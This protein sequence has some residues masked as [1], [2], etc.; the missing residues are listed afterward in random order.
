M[1]LTEAVAPPLRLF[2][3]RC[4][5]TGGSRKLGRELCVAFAKAGAKVAFT[6]HKQDADAEVTRQLLQQAG[7]E[8]LV[9]KGSVTDADHARA[10][11]NDIVKAW[12]GLDVLVNN[13]GVMQILPVALLE[14]ADWDKVIDT[15][16]K[17]AYI[18]SREV[19]RPMLRA[20]KG[21]IL[22]IGSIAGERIVEAPIHYAAA[23]AGL[24]GLTRALA[25]EVGRFGIAVND[26]SAGLLAA[27][28]GQQALQHHRDEYIKNCPLGRLGTLEELAAFATWLVSDENSFMSGA[29]LA[30]DGG[31]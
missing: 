21:H 25:R 11:V 1:N 31:L 28:L 12:G 7:A 15:N 24:Q 18:F 19:L 8:V 9:F 6:Y 2:G 20:K 10:T 16:L 3:K 26:L 4:L 27:G 5:V 13:A 23:K 14:E 29:R 17:G 30:F 22:N